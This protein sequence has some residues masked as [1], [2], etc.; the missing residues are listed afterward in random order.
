MVDRD[1]CEV[2]HAMCI[3]VLIV[4]VSLSPGR[5]EAQHVWWDVKGQDD[6]TCLYGE[7]SPLATHGCTCGLMARPSI[8]GTGRIGRPL[9]LKRQR[10][11]ARPLAAMMGHN[12]AALS[13]REKA[14][15]SP[16]VPLLCV[17]FHA[18]R[19]LLR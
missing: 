16:I 11:L 6:A 12:P 17:F 4:A 2:S 15:A 1:E 14:H 19:V 9:D 8:T 3:I 5:A 10:Y 18:G 13:L 7:T